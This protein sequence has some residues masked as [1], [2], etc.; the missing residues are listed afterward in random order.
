MSYK[1]S[2]A[3][4]YQNLDNR[5]DTSNDEN[6]TMKKACNWLGSKHHISLKFLVDLKL[7]WKWKIS[8]HA[9]IEIPKKPV[10][11]VTGTLFNIW[12]DELEMGTKEG[13]S[14]SLSSL[15]IV[16]GTSKPERC[17]RIIHH[18]LAIKSNGISCSTSQY[19][20]LRFGFQLLY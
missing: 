9:I 12:S 5:S 20:Q 13:M 17:I 14:S 18:W 1:A 7:C 15:S 4:W 11:I 2:K 8:K 6:D 16:K 3:F 19:Q 10:M